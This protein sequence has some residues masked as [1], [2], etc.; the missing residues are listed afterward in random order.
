MI[1]ILIQLEDARKELE[2]L[3]QENAALLS[4]VSELLDVN[5]HLK[6]QTN[7]DYENSSIPSSQKP[8]HKMP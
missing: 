5:R 8:N 7:R 6:A 4:Q 1:E 3:R 2:S